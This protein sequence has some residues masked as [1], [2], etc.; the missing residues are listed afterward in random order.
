MKI[1]K[2]IDDIF[3]SCLLKIIEILVASLSILSV[4]VLAILCVFGWCA[5]RVLKYTLLIGSFAVA[6]YLVYLI[7]RLFI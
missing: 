4:S 2:K 7:V 5:I 3:S 6:V 1:F